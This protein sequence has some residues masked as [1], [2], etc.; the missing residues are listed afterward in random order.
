MQNS[1]A[2][3]I[4]ELH[5]MSNSV[6]EN[7]KPD[8]EK[9][10]EVHQD[11]R[12][13]LL[14]PDKSSMS[15]RPSN[16]SSIQPTDP[17]NCTDNYRDA[18]KSLRSALQGDAGSRDD[19]YNPGELDASGMRVELMVDVGEVSLKT[20]DIK[21]Q[22]DNAM[23]YKSAKESF[24]ESGNDEVA[25]TR[26]GE[27]CLRDGQQLSE[28]SSAVQDISLNVV[29]H[30]SEAKSDMLSRS[31]GIE[32]LIDTKKDDVVVTDT[33]VQAEVALKVEF[34]KNGKHSKVSTSLLKACGDQSSE[35]STPRAANSTHET[36]L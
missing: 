16:S 28:P 8:M 29:A 6:G 30:R 7:V 5:P 4:I 32:A 14:P 9:Y 17:N 23:K 12:Q 19:R 22:V 15:T 24:Y 2:E 1:V 26:D 35:V 33:K 11:E 25:A 10:V 27:E 13:R 36:M 20:V 31:S 3:E 21:T 34:T 18:E